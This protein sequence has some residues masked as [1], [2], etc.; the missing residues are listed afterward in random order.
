MSTCQPVGTPSPPLVLMYTSWN[1]TSLYTRTA[2]RKHRQGETRYPPLVKAE[3]TAVARMT[4]GTSSTYFQ[5]ALEY[6][7]AAFLQR[8]SVAP[9]VT[10]NLL[11]IYTYCVDRRV[12]RA[13]VPTVDSMALRSTRRH[14]SVTSL[15]ILEAITLNF[16]S[17]QY[18]ALKSPSRASWAIQRTQL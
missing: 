9:P 10:V 17:S 12:C 14:S 2:S 5:L 3:R 1:H 16:R 8:C 18:R 6:R 4:L 15:L 7:L 11:F 13:L